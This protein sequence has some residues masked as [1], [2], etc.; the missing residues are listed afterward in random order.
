M[1]TIEAQ[2]SVEIWNESDKP[3]GGC[4]LNF[5]AVAEESL[6]VDPLTTWPI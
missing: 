2:N 5:A 1:Q 3:S 6:S 4:T